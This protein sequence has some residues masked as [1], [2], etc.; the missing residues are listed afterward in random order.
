MSIRQRNQIVM[1]SLQKASL[2]ISPSEYLAK[3]FIKRG[4]P[5]DKIKLINNG[6]NLRE[7]SRSKTRSK[8][9]RFAYIGQIIEHKG[10]VNLLQALS[11][12]DDKE[13]EKISV[14]I[15]GS[16]IKV[17][18][19]FCKRLAKELFSTNPPVF[20]GAAGNHK[21]PAILKNIDAIIVPSVWPEN[22]P[23]SIMEALAS[24]TPVLGSDFGGIPEL[25][26]DNRTGLLHKYDQPA[27]L[28]DNIRKVIR[29]PAMLKDM[30]EACLRKAAESDLAQQVRKIAD[31][32]MRILES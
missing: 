23:V 25:V 19:D 9:I 2:L 27:S 24:G 11:V 30:K 3:E 26:Q 10:I 28:A 16:G 4:I 20:Y 5:R 22:S 31:E 1:H 17:Y 32:Y 15:V 13:R 6:I 18:V 29:D 12:L 8:K 14:L 7:F 21:V